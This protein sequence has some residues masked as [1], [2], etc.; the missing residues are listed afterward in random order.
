[1][2][3]FCEICENL[4]IA[5]F[6]NDELNFKCMACSTSYPANPVDTL[7]YENTKDPEVSNFAKILSKSS[8]DPI[9]LKAKVKCIKNNCIGTIVKEVRIG[10]ELHLYRVCTVCN[11]QW[12]A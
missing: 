1:M 10:D 7:R 2:S 6:I 3:K 12:L 8:S 9:T 5:T 4:L 11:S